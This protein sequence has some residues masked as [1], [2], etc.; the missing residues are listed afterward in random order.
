[1]APTERWELSQQELAAAY[2]VEGEWSLRS[3]V[4]VLARAPSLIPESILLAVRSCVRA[5]WGDVEL[6]VLLDSERVR[7]AL[8]GTV[9]GA[10]WSPTHTFFDALAPVL[11]PQLSALEIGCGVGRVSRVVAPEV[12]ELVC[13]DI[14]RVMVREARTNLARLDNVRVQ[15]TSGYWLDGL[16][17]SRFDLVFSHAVFVFFDLYP[18]IAMLDAVRRVLHPGGTS[19]IGFMTM[20]RPQWQVEA[21]ETARRSARRG[22]FGARC[23]RPYTQEQ[24]R[25]MHRAVGLEV[26]E[27]GYGATTAEDHH[28]PL[29]VTAVAS[30][31]P[32]A[33][34]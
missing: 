22:T 4:R 5:V 27:C 10:A 14:S 26:L 31:R 1:M 3:L 15:R 6:A 30:S 25:A 11:G 19:V 12:K 33:G 9:R 2:A 32:P 29:V 24:V 13:T 34:G 7:L 23:V 17:D 18:A 16:E 21:V 8:P 20:D 28:P